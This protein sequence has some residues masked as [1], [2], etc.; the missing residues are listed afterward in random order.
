MDKTIARKFLQF[1]TLIIEL[2]HLRKNN[3]DATY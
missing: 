3:S 2:V 1:G